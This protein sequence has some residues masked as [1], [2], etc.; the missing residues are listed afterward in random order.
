[1]PP[2][3]AG[4]MVYAD[5]ST[6]LSVGHR[7]RLPSRHYRGADAADPDHAGVARDTGR[8]TGDDHHRSPGEPAGFD[9]WLVDLT[10]VSSVWPTIG[11]TND[12]TQVG[13]R[14]LGL[15]DR[16]EGKNRSVSGVGQLPGR[17]TEV[18]ATRNF[19]LIRL[20]TSAAAGDHATGG[21]VPDDV[22]DPSN[23][24]AS[25]FSTIRAIVWTVSTGYS[26]TPSRRRA[27]PRPPCRDRIG[28][29]RCL[30]PGWPW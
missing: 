2:L 11:T 18:K 7:V 21:A 29:I 4:G 9:Q 23:S 24:C 8:G 22:L 19:A 3:A 17:I 14:E 25:V 5:G 16:G 12:S 26:P 15:L 27:S 30:G 6:R 1:M 20:A 10:I 13:Q 28:H